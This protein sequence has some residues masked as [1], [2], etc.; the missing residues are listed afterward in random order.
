LIILKEV[1]LMSVYNE[2]KL[3]RKKNIYRIR[4]GFLILL[5]NPMLNVVW[6]PVILMIIIFDNLKN[7]YISSLNVPKILSSVL[8]ISEKILTFL[9]PAILVFTVIYVIGEF[10]AKSD[11]NNLLLAFDEKDLKKGNPILISKKKMN[12]KKV[13]LREF[14]TNIPLNKWNEKKEDIAHIM[15]ITIIGNIQYS[16]KNLIQF[17]SVIGRTPKE[18]VDLY[19]DI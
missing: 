3:R 18:S 13:V 17:K 2:N 11:E 10:L 9:I 5:N 1:V 14:Y 8:Y 12:N 4:L 16:K 15:D 6:I 7:I 19:D